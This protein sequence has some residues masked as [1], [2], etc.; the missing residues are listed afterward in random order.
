M[1][2]LKT[3]LKFKLIYIGIAFAG[4]LLSL[5]LWELQVSGV[6]NVCNTGGCGNVLTSEWSKLGG[7]PMAVFGLFYYVIFLLLAI[8]HLV[9][10]HPLILKLLSISLVWGI[11]FSIYLRYLEFFRIGHLCMLCWISV[12]MIALLSINH[13][14]ERRYLRSHAD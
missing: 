9:D 5:Y 14:L 3:G 4:C 10:K 2:I 7:V 12:V 6:L 11:I 8:I 1:A 13:F